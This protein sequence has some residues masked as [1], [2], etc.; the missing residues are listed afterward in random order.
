MIVFG[1]LTGKVVGDILT[2]V[3]HHVFPHKILVNLRESLHNAHVASSGCRMEFDENEW[4][5]SSILW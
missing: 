3:L 1:L 4:Y 2:N 5:Y